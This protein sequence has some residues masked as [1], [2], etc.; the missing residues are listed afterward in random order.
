MAISNQELSELKSRALVAM[1][2]GTNIARVA[3]LIMDLIREA[4]PYLPERAKVD[5]DI[6][7][8]YSIILAIESKRAN[9]DSTP[10][11]AK[12]EPTPVVEAAPEITTVEELESDTDNQ[13]SESV[14]ES[15]PDHSKSAPKNKGGKQS[16]K[17]RK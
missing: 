11:V 12:K 3:D 16:K 14:E 15:A 7:Y 9:Q 17:D 5:T 2:T 1:R 13:W 8:L 6:E 4:S 10:K